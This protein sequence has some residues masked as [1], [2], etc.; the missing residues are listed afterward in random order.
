MHKLVFVVLMLI[1]WWTLHAIQ[2][3]E[4]LALSVVHEG[5]RAVDR[6]AHAA[7]QQID[8]A[9]LE[10]GV[11]AID[12]DKAIASAALYL[13]ENLRLEADLSPSEDGYLREPVEVKVLD[14]VD[15]TQ[16][17]PYR[18]RNDEYDYEVTFRRPGVVLIAHIV[19]P[20]VF[21]ALPPIEWELKGAAELVY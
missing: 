8:E 10:A 21:A 20:R 2:V 9:K 12:R 6:A 16:A 13:K 3:D 11:P 7:A 14:I 1:V 19:Y 15:E 17:F 18:Y 4:E 5:K